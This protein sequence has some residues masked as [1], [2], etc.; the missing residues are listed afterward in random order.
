MT[1]RTEGIAPDAALRM[2]S[3][4]MQTN[5]E[6]DFNFLLTGIAGGSVAP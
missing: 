5:Y 2:S 6:I 4:L 1:G 3:T